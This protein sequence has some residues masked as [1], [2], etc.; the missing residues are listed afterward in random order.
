[1][2]VHIIRLLKKGGMFT[3]EQRSKIELI[4]QMEENVQIL[5]SLK[6]QIRIWL[7]TRFKINK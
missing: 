5:D 7:I 6:F 1:M 4:I 3:V 2:S